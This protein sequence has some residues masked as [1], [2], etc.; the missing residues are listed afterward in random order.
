[1]RTTSLHVA[2][3]RL[4]FDAGLERYPAVTVLDGS[5]AMLAFPHITGAQA[6]RP[7]PQIG[8][9]RWVRDADHEKRLRQALSERGY[10]E[11]QT[12]NLVERWADARSD[13]ASR[14]AA[15]L[16]R[17]NVDLIIAASTPA[18]HAAHVASRSIPIVSAGMADS[19]A[20][21]F[22]VSLA[23]AGRISP[24]SHTIC[25]RSGQAPR[26]VMT[27]LALK[28]RLPAMSDFPDFAEASGLCR[29]DQAVARPRNGW[30]RTWTGFS[31]APG[32]ANC[33]SASQRRSIS[34]SI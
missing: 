30:R 4:P 18:V 12:V 28:H 9:L 29:T 26:T 11:G 34:S 3:C 6:S 2:P 25:R 21:G 16:V 7:M 13:A 19:I 10:V 33:R 5:L 20:S 23:R 31:R 22:A 32:R 27:Q 15:E 8:V 1:L 17:A 24:G 14:A